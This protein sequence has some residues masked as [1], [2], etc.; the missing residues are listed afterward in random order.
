MS[1]LIVA[2]RV[3]MLVF[4]VAQSST[5]HGR[6]SAKRADI[7]QSERV[8]R[9]CPSCRSFVEVIGAI[10]APDFDRARNHFWQAGGGR[11]RRAPSGERLAVPGDFY[12]TV[13]RTC[14]RWLRHEASRRRVQHVHFDALAPWLPELLERVDLGQ[15]GDLPRCRD[16]AVRVAARLLGVSVRTVYANLA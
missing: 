9:P 14:E 11:F 16:A 2:D 6:A 10:R 5:G 4:M 13:V 8:A 12:A 1:L 15:G 7:Q 3:G